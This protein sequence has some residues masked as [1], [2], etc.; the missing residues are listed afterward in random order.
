MRVS[1]R[2]LRAV[3]S[4]GV[5][6]RYAVMGEAAF[7]LAEIP[8]TGS[9]GTSLDEP[10]RREHWGIVHQG[11]LLL[12]GRHERR[13]AAGT[14]FY[15]APGRTHRFFADGPA[16]VAGFA[17]VDTEIDDSPEGRRA[18]GLESVRRAAVPHLPPTEVRIVGARARTGT[19]GTVQTVSAVMGRWVFT[20]SIF[21]P[22]GG[23]GDGWCELPHW[24]QVIDGT[25]LLHWQSGEIELLSAGDI[26]A[27]PLGV[28][29]HRIEVADAA[30]MI[31]YTPIDAILDPSLRRAPRTVA[32]LRDALPGLVHPAATDAAIT[33]PQ[34]RS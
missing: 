9:A 14:A 24:G 13:F 29:G 15:V 3:R 34:R 18:R 25:M 1:P 2:E 6:T 16:V 4:R 26:F 22:I 31:D 8:P 19:A 17:P 7:F 28:G 21:G 20:R 32:A 30:T 12:R 23:F 11:E 10:C 27:C 5:L 33:V